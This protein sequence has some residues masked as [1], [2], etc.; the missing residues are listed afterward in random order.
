MLAPPLVGRTQERA[1]LVR[2]LAG[3]GPPLL[4]LTGEPGIGKSRLLANT[5]GTAYAQGWTTLHGGC[6]RRSGQ[7]PYAPIVGALTRFL[8]SRTP[9]QRCQELAGC[10]WLMRLLPEFADA[11]V[12]PTPAWI[13]PSEQERRLMFEAVVRFARNVAG[14]A[15]TLLVL[16]DLHRA[17]AD[18]LDLLATLAHAGA[19]EGLRLVGAYRATDVRSEHP[20]AIMVADLA[21]AGLVQQAQVG[22][23]AP[24]EA[25]ELLG[26]LLIEESAQVE[27]VEQVLDRCGGGH[28]TWRATRAGCVRDWQASPGT[29]H[30]AFS[31]GW[32]H[33]PHWHETYS[34][35]RPS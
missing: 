8:S 35:L 34:R 29:W 10:E 27:Q 2:H 28:F 25:A 15:G 20:L 11:T 32:R 19:E 7:E 30:R 31:S 4:L 14:P 13:L 16:D 17:G 33:C 3:E 22:P 18:A 24:T 1:L 26:R 9:A 12:V 21:Q 23:L 5:L 6:S